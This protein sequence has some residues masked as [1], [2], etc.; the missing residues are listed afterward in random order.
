[1]KAKDFLR[2][3]AED[4]QIRDTDLEALLG[5]SELAPIELPDSFV[6]KFNESY[7]TRDRAINDS[8]IVSEIQKKTK[9]QTFDKVDELLEPFY[10]LLSPEKAKEI[11]KEKVFQ[12]YER[13]EKLSENLK[14]AFKKK[15]GKVNEDVQKIEAE[16]SAKFKTLQDSAKAEKETLLNNFKQ[17]KID[18]SLKSRLLGYKFGEAYNS[19][20]EP[21][22]KN[23][24]TKIKDL[25]H[26]GN[27][28]VIETDEAGN[29][30]LRQSVEGTLRDIYIKDNDKLTIE[31][32]LDQ[33]VDPFI[34]KSN[35]GGNPGGSGAGGSNP[36]NPLLD[37]DES[38]MTLHDL[39]IKRHLA[40]A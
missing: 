15:D 38:K 17:E 22:I 36:P 6:T 33:E 3:K 23:I 31:K 21:I 14:E 13:I 11:G 29:V 19:L 8:S 7:M 34:V 24:I 40:Q 28:V 30:L 5:S 2:K 37:A 35:G 39:M 32:L 1:M 26:N 25:K 27:P 10:S 9:A 20:K 18:N 16:W 12:T 4:A